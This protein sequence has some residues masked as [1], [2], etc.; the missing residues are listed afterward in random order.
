MKFSDLQIE[1]YARH[2]LLPEIG[3]AGQTKIMDGRVL[4]VGAGG[5]GS[6]VLLYL[7][8]AGVG[9]IGIIDD[10]KIELSN[11]QR[12]IIHTTPRVGK[13]KVESARDAVE[14]LT[15]TLNYKY[16]RSDLRLTM[17]SSCSNTMTS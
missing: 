2:I 5:L 16:M 9:T 7:A 13:P 3:G 6:P 12:Q 10:D 14:Q 8:A 11:L 15:R 17:L 4:V 1:R